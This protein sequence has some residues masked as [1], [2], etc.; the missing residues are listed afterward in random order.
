MLHVD[1]IGCHPDCPGH[2]P[3]KGF[4][5]MEKNIGGEKFALP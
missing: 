5:L 4:M 2:D 3:E 1:R